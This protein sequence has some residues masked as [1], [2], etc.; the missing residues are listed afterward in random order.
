MKKRI[1]IDDKEYII[2]GDKPWMI[3]DVQKTE[4]N[5]DGVIVI[6]SNML[7][8]ALK[9]N[10]LRY[11]SLA[12]VGKTGAELGVFFVGSQAREKA[13]EIVFILNNKL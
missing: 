3:L 5:P 12:R 9:S 13:E 6:P 8:H 11:N 4:R 10:P 1:L 2:Y 7:L